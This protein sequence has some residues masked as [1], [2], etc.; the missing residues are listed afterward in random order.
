[1]DFSQQVSSACGWSGWHVVARA[2]Y[3]RRRFSFDRAIS[4][5]LK[6]LQN[7]TRIEHEKIRARKD[8]AKLRMIDQHSS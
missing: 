4:R 7:S 5:L 1:M 2:G 6:I 3:S 8:E